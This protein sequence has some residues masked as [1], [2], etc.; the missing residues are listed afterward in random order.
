ML[1]TARSCYIRV[2][3]HVFLITMHCRGEEHRSLYTEDFVRGSL[4]GGSTV[5]ETRHL[6]CMILQMA[7]DLKI[8]RNKRNFHLQ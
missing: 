6:V 8:R 5:F 7:P 4:K 3:R 2:L 1:A